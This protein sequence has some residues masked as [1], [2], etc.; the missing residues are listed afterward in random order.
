[1]QDIAHLHV[2]SVYSLLDGF[3]R[4]KEL[5]EKTK[6]EGFK[7]VAITDKNNLFGAVKFYSEA[8]KQGIKPIV[9]IEISVN[10][11]QYGELSRVLLYVKNTIG[12]QNL[13]LLSS[14]SY[15]NNA[16]NPYISI[17]N[18][19]N[20]SEGIIAVI[21]IPNSELYKYIK[22]DMIRQAQDVLRTYL[23]IFSTDD[24]YLQVSYGLNEDENAIA[25]KKIA[26]AKNY[27][28]SPIA[29]NEVYYLNKEDAIYQDVLSCIRNGDLLENENR[30]KLPSDNYYY[31]S[32]EEMIKL[33]DFCPEALENTG[34]LAQ[35]CNFEFE[36]GKIYMPKFDVKNGKLA[37]DLLRENCYKGIES[38]YG[39]EKKSNLDIVDRLE[40]ELS[41]IIDMGF[42]DYFLICEDYVRYAKNNDIQV[43]PAR[44]SGAGSLVCYLLEITDVDPLKYGLLFERFLNPERIDMP[45]L[46]I[47]FQDDRISEVIDYV[48]EKYGEDRVARI[49]TFGTLKAKAV[50]KDVARV[51]NI[52]IERA[53]TLSSYI[54]EPTINETI[55]RSVKFKEFYLKSNEYKRLINYAMAI[56]GLPRHSSI[57]AAGVVISRDI[58]SK[59]VPT[60]IKT[61]L[62]TQYDMN[63]VKNLGLLKMDFL[64][65]NALS[66]ISE[67]L[68][69][70]KTDKNFDVESF[71]RSF[72]DKKTY[73]LLSRGDSLGVFQLES[74]DMIRFIRQLRPV[75]IEDII[76]GIS[77]F[78]PG[79]MD[80]IPMLIHN[81]KFP[82]D[83]HY[84]NHLL[85][86]ILDETYGCLV[87]QEQVMEIARILAGFSYARADKI[88]R[89]MSKKKT[90]IMQ[91]E[92]Q[93]FIYGNEDLGIRGAI[94]NGISEELAKKIY[95]R[96]SD[97][98]KYAF[99]KSHATGY[100]II[101][102]R[103]A[104]LKANYPK[105]Y[106]VALLNSELYSSQKKKLNQY[107]NEA[108]KF[109]IGIL[110]PSIE[111]SK[112]KFAIENGNI[113]Y[114]LTALKYLSVNVAKDIEE[115]QNKGD[116]PK[117]LEDFYKLMPVGSLNKK[118][119][120][121][122]SLSGA[123]DCFGVN[124]RTII[125]N[126]EEMYSYRNNH[127]GYSESQ[128]TLTDFFEVEELASSNYKL[129]SE[130]DED[131]LKS[132]FI[133]IT[134]L[135]NTKF[136]N[137]ESS[138]KLYVKMNEL[139]DEE[140]KYIDKIARSEEGY[141]FIVYE[142]KYKRL[143]KFS[144]KIDLNY[145]I[146]NKLKE[147]YGD[148]NIKIEKV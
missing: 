43:G 48:T 79:P 41:V 75:N 114:G 125:E 31:R 70:V 80:S 47:D 83:I 94:N 89:A 136:L 99:N 77:I 15:Q 76:I 132:K 138:Y 3:V 67:V 113:R 111:K 81:R 61:K 90:D 108:I 39:I 40:K 123:L 24:I 105:H 51:L 120:E 112:S 104:Y 21:G 18:I 128:M 36:F 11:G 137:I 63:D 49:I 2:H 14:I 33:F 17:Q 35:K 109:K 54:S 103:M 29:M 44:G 82:R 56:E 95:S 23:A 26:F 7:S 106:I 119:I 84:D 144:Y 147:K 64:S 133:E 5:C 52:D 19:A 134:G 6:E 13:S 145:D 68:E 65:L 78:R 92:K 58:T 135:E 59:L 139:N 143:R 141:E 127:Y 72:D 129:Y 69:L 73:K 126:F 93:N 10:L 131:Y 42:E 66:I 55:K 87:Y 4:I 27:G 22:N 9:G 101:A 146:L 85:K 37:K 57:H 117:S 98:A 16:D 88:R 60:M 62:C 142:E 100:A 124:K 71:Y 12:Y 122:L 20:H 148:S 102:Y 50:I 34:K 96:I 121:S 45:D 32:K 8:K 91:E 118:S 130:Y 74:K 107:F 140:K 30:E 28:I 97:F 53:N 110:P 86:N 1:M 38:R 25:S 116:F 115:L 46:D